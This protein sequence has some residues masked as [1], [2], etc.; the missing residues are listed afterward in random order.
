MAQTSDALD[1][2]AFDA[3][4]TSED[5]VR[6]TSRKRVVLFAL[7]FI[8]L[9]VVATV[10]YIIFGKLNSF[11]VAYALAIVVV[12]ITAGLLYLRG[13]QRT[14]RLAKFAGLNNL[15]FT[16]QHEPHG[17]SGMIF[18]EGTSRQVSESLQFEDGVEIG[19]YQYKVNTGNGTAIRRWAYMR[20]QLKKPLPHVVLDRHAN[21]ALGGILSNLPEG[22]KR[23]Q[24]VKLEGNFNEHFDM[25]IPDGYQT[26]ARYVF[27]PDVMAALID[28]GQDYDLEIIDNDLYFYGKSKPLDRQE[29]QERL[30]VVNAI[31]P[32]LF[33]QSKNYADERVETG[34][35]GESIATS[36]KRLKLGLRPTTIVI[37]VVVVYML[38][39]LINNIVVPLL[40]R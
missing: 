11:I 18:N 20:I 22:F 15:I 37:I 21:N 9:P 14:A 28:N 2:S 12:C 16:R 3:H 40:F 33:H 29:V 5:I 19:N 17:L 10:L 34:T 30:K 35:R 25:Y 39:N 8:A 4:V 36:G 6:Y 32:E 7:K 1:F 31:V 24:A 38:L 27:T 13:V 23:S 26:D